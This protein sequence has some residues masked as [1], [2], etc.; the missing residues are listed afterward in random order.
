MK[1]EANPNLL[2][3]QWKGSPNFYAMISGEIDVWQKDVVDSYATLEDMMHVD[4]AKGA[5]LDL[6]ALRLGLERPNILGPS[7]DLK[8]GFKSVSRSRSFDQEEYKGVLSDEARYP[9]A[10]SLFRK[11]IKARGIALTSHGEFNGFNRSVKQL[12]ANAICTDNRNMS[13]TIE[14]DETTLIQM[15]DNLG[16]I[17]RPIGVNIINRPA[18]KFGFEGYGAGFDRAE[19][20]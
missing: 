10:D 13:V 6:I 8:F 14:S 9:L 4:T 18:R 2:I 1:L 16:A 17:P 5:W 19:Y 15:A 7:T 3:Q 11:I 20:E 12:D